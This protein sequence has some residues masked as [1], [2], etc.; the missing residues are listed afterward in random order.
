[1][2]FIRSPSIPDSKLVIEYE[3]HEPSKWYFQSPE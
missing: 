3:G 1:M 2:E